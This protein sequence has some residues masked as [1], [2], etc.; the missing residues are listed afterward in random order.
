MDFS[1]WYGGISGGINSLW[2]VISGKEETRLVKERVRRKI[3]REFE[4]RL[5][6]KV[7]RKGF[8]RGVWGIGVREERGSYRSVGFRSFE[9][10]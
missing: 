9:R 6:F 8:F 4:E 3:K 5:Y 10:E 2:L 1:R 7:G